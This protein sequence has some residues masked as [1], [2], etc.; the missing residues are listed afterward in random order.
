[1]LAKTWFS[2]QWNIVPSRDI[3]WLRAVCTFLGGLIYLVK[4]VTNYGG[5]LTSCL[6]I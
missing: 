4:I 3:N 1:M 5:F 6:L 2:W